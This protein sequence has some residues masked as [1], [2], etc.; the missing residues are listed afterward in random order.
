MK[1]LAFNGGEISPPPCHS[2]PIWTQPSRS[3][4]LVTNRDIHATGGIS[5]RRGMR[6]LTTTPGRNQFTATANWRTMPYIGIQC[7][8]NH[9]C[10]ILAMQ[11]E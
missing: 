1:R 2:A 10:T 6:L 7:T 8:G 4:S 11:L 9:P 5:R 3:C